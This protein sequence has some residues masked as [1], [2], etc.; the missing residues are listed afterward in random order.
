[1]WLHHNFIPREQEHGDLP[2]VPDDRHV[3]EKQISEGSVEM[4]E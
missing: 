3:L 4:T 2:D 1:M